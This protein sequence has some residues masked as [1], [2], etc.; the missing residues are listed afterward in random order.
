MELVDIVGDLI[1]DYET[2]NHP[3]PQATGVEALKFLMQQHGL[4]QSDLAFQPLLSY[5]SPKRAL[6]AR[7]R[8]DC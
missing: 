2:E 4:K 5:K 8:I 6:A 1:E 7:T 3:T